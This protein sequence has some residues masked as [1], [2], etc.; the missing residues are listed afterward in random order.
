MV[1]KLSSSE[2]VPLFLRISA[3]N[4]MEGEGE[5]GREGERGKVGGR[6][7]SKERGRRREG[8]IFDIAM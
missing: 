4:M 6:R 3:K 5:G 7:N 2:F 1:L 8:L